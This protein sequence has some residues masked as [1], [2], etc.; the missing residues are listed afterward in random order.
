MLIE[1]SQL[2]RNE[3]S[4]AKANENRSIIYDIAQVTQ[5]KVHMENVCLF[6]VHVLFSLNHV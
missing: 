5:E 3:N 2:L 1:N 4:L 6:I